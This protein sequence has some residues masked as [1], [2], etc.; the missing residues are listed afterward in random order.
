M[1]ALID[2]LFRHRVGEAVEALEHVQARLLALPDQ[3]PA[4]GTAVGPGLRTA[5]DQ[6]P[7]ICRNLD[8]AVAALRT[9]HDPAGNAIA[10]SQ[11]GTGLQHLVDD[12]SGPGV[13]GLMRVTLD[14]AGVRQFE[15]LVDELGRIAA[16]LRH[17]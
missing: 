5:Q 4:R 9:G 8:D 10:A 6:I 14:D 16:R 15:R 13:A 2:R 1:S 7:V 3:H 17:R 11:V 12:A